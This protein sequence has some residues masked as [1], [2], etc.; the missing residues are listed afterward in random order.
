MPYEPNLEEEH[1]CIKAK[2]KAEEP[3]IIERERGA[4]SL[5]EGKEARGYKH[6][7]R[8]KR[9][10]RIGMKGLWTCSQFEINIAP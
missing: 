4:S 7:Y 6:I 5:G 9:Y 1:T 8:R 3:K 10:V 2:P